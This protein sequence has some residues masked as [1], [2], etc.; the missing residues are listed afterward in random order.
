MKYLSDI[1]TDKALLYLE[2]RI[3]K[4]YTAA[5]KEISLIASEY[6]EKFEKRYNEEYKAYKRGAYT[7]K[8]FE[9]WYVAQVGRGLRYERMRDK[10]AKRIVNA[11]KVA[12][13][14][15][16][17]STPS[18]VTLN[19]NYEA[20]LIEQNYDN[21]AFDIWDEQTVKNLIGRKQIQLPPAKVSIPKSMR[22]N[23]QKLQS[24]LL[25]AILQGQSVR[26]LAG[27]FNI[28]AQMG[29]ASAIRNARTAYTCAQNAG[30]Q[31][32]YE[33]AFKMGIVMQKEWICTQ[34]SRTRDSHKR[35]DG[36]V[37][38]YD[39]QFPNGLMYPADPDG[40]PAEIYNCRCTMRAVFDGINQ[41]RQTYEE[42]FTNGT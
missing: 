39:E 42:W 4:E 38:D 13:S 28:I 35:M 15:I 25:S 21:I 29:S 22:W 26:E 20:Y 18:I 6:F 27:N 41:S 11:D 17:D 36:V 19:R 40:K 33:E 31:K 3:K 2:K 32:S 16:N 8:Q 24:A 5:G 1:E 23:R 34:D 12:A 14:Y 9:D 10:C 7:K 37:V 30:R